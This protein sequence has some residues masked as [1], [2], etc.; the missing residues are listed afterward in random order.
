VSG[1]RTLE[2]YRLAI[3][4]MAGAGAQLILGGCSV[5]EYSETTAPLLSG[6]KSAR[7]LDVAIERITIEPGNMDGQPCIR[8]LPVK[9]CDVYR[10]LSL[11]GMTEGEILQKYPGLE[12]EDLPAVR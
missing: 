9:F 3:K 11:H 7:E 4:R 8:A 12:P 6:R 10:G 1:H 5:F 2:F